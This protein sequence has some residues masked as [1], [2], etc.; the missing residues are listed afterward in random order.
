MKHTYPDTKQVPFYLYSQLPEERASTVPHYPK[1]CSRASHIWGQHTQS[2]MNK[3]R[4]GKTTYVIM[5]SP[6]PGKYE[7]P[8][9][10][11]PAHSSSLHSPGTVT[12]SA[13]SA[14]SGPSAP[15]RLS[16][17]PRSA[18]DQPQEPPR[19]HTQDA[20]TQVKRDQQ[21]LHA[22]SSTYATPLRGCLRRPL[23]RLGD[24]GAH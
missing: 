8:P 9:T 2:T 4:P 22:C 15:A 21:P 24:R 17:W 11:R 5:V 12:S 16:P 13:D 3:P 6:L 23:L 18:V 20:Q 7:F 19:V 14:H 10:H 1:L